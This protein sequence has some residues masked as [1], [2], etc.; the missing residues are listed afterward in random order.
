MQQ[1]TVISVIIPHWTG[2]LEQKGPERS[3]GAY[4]RWLWRNGKVSDLSRFCVAIK[5]EV[6]GMKRFY[7]KSASAAGIKWDL[8]R[9]S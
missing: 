2:R 6:G 5:C 4:S 9:N 3:N 1:N 8:Q 7:L